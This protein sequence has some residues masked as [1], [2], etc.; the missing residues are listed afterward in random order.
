MKFKNNNDDV[1]KDFTLQTKEFMQGISVAKFIQYL[2][3]KSECCWIGV[4]DINDNRIIC[5]W[6]NLEEVAGRL[7]KDFLVTSKGQ[8][9]YWNDDNEKIELL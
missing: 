1:W 6:Y 9:Y 4:V 8:L 2:R 5:T 3:K 7:Y